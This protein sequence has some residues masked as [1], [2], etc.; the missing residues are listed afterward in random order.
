MPD[1]LLEEIILLEKQ[2]QQQLKKEECRVEEWQKRELAGL[3]DMLE[4]VRDTTRSL[5]EAK[6]E[7]TRKQASIDGQELVAKEEQWCARV[8]GFDDRVLREALTQ[9]L[10]LI[11][12]EEHGDHS[13][14]Q[15]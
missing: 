6:Q 9:V 13:N 1:G 12:P 14:G 10:P 15:S 7:A 5:V 2:I 8:K 11:F 4:R 3:D